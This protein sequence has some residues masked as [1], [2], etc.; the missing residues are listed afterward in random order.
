[1]TTARTEQ[2][3]QALTFIRK[4]SDRVPR[5]GI[6]LGSGLGALAN[7]VANA[8]RISYDD[9]PHFP[10]S[11]V[12]GHAGALVL[13]ELDGASVAVFQ[14]RIH[15]YE[16]YDMFGVTFPVRLMHGLGAQMMIVT[17]AVG[18][19]S[20]TL[21][22]GDLVAI[23]DHINFMGT[24][25]LRGPNLDSMGPRFPD[26]VNCYDERLR[27]VAHEVAKEAGI[28]LKEGVYIA[29]SGPSYETRAEIQFMRMI[30]ADTVG[31][32]TA[33]ETI[34]ARHVGM[35]VLGISCVTDV[36]YGDYQEVSHEEVLAVA[37]ESGP[38]FVKLV[39][40]IVQRLERDCR[41]AEGSSRASG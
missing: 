2:L 22:N 28:S 40:A 41:T 4:H 21:T 19:I 32:S 33:P 38:R 31:M 18:G 3:Q 34:V 13:G 8:V 23:R 12:A 20:E 1:M 36:L 9:I 25:P 14:G 10:T 7:E 39:R 6:V 15:F 16:G 27:S 37:K 11:T 17:N 24:N 35:R 30:G 26:M 29:V 5:F